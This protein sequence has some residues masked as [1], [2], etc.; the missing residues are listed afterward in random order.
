VL[1]LLHITYHTPTKGRKI[2][3]GP[4]VLDNLLIRNKILLIKYLFKGD[5]YNYLE[6]KK[7]ILFVNCF[8]SREFLLFQLEERRVNAMATDCDISITSI[9]FY[10]PR[11]GRY[12][13]SVL[14]PVYGVETVS[15]L[16]SALKKVMSGLKSTTAA[17]YFGPFRRF[18]L[19]GGLDE[20]AEHVGNR[21]FKHL[22][23][24]DLNAVTACDIE[25]A[26]LGCFDRLS[27]YDDFSFTTSTND[28]TRAGFWDG[29]K[30]IAGLLAEIGYFPPFRIAGTIP[31]APGTRTPVLKTSV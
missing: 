14:V 5:K 24:N 7:I 31:H 21:L 28:K 4:F 3:N 22:R 20:N 2:K 18:L 29:I 9:D 17:N 15:L 30:R 6:T 12:D 26:L 23:R 27:D 19:Q 25:Q 8:Q 13:L 16:A 1:I 11:H 10:I